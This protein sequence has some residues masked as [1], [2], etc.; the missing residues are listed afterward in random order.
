MIFG[1][2]R[3]IRLMGFFWRVKKTQ[4]DGLVIDFY[5]R[6][7]TFI[8]GAN[9]GEPAFIDAAFLP[10]LRIFHISRFAQIAKS[11]VCAVAVNMVY[12]LQWPLACLMQPRQ[13]VRQMKSVIQ[14]N[15]LIPISHSTPCFGPRRTTTPP[16]VPRKHPGFGVI[17]D[18]FTKPLGCKFV[19][20]S[21]VNINKAMESQA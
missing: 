21:S 17:V 11:V 12:L 3:K 1:F 20:H 16:S 13:P 5:F 9:A 2:S 15:G 8:F 7:P 18:Q 6:Q 19:F 10:I 4:P 14:S